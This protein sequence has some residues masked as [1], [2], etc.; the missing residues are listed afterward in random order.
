MYLCSNKYTTLNKTISIFEKYI[1][2]SSSKSILLLK[3]CFSEIKLTRIT[4]ITFTFA[5]LTFIYTMDTRQYIWWLIYSV[6]I[7][8]HITIDSSLSLFDDTHYSLIFPY[9]AP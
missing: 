8:F 2:N 6:H 5:L 7:D 3:T 1:F 9:N 4:M